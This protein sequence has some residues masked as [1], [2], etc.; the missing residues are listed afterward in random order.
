MA[1]MNQIISDVGRVHLK[2]ALTD[3][4]NFASGLGYAPLPE[5]VVD[6]SFELKWFFFSQKAS[7]SSCPEAPRR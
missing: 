3:G 5:N 7:L 2:W 1:L 6:P 4:Q